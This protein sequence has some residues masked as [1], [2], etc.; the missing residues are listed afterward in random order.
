MIMSNGPYEQPSS[1]SRMSGY[2]GVGMWVCVVGMDGEQAYVER[3]E[4]EGG[5]NVRCTRADT[6]EA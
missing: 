2:V 4:E 5:L 1:S 6:D 3:G